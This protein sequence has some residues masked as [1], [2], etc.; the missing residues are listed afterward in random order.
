VVL[1][2]MSRGNRQYE[3]RRKWTVLLVNRPGEEQF[4]V[5]GR[6]DTVWGWADCVDYVTST[7]KYARSQGGEQ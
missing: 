7:I 2:A 6:D 4:M 3:L 5:A 1:V